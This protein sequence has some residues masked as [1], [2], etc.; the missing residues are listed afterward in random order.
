MALM[1]RK[2]GTR[3]VAALLVFS[4]L[5]SLTG[6]FQKYAIKEGFDYAF[7]P[8]P[9]M[10]G[11]KSSN[12]TF[13]KESVSFDLYYG[14]HNIGY[15]EK[16]GTDPRSTYIKSPR[17]AE[18]LFALY[19]VIEEYANDVL[20]DNEL[21]DYKNIKHHLFIKELS[22]EEAFSEEYGFKMNYFTGIS[23]NHSESVTIPE[24]LFEKDSGRIAIKIIAM[25]KPEQEDG[26]FYTS[27]ARHVSISYETTENGH[28]KITGVQD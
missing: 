3:V 1:K 26:K 17:S 20:N 25:H 18:L 21:D 15:T 28:I 8:E 16:H 4:A 2:I 19:F 9:I 6:C 23:F 13:E 5:C 12:D 7:T 10:F 22:E 24:E 14:V 11:I 27:C